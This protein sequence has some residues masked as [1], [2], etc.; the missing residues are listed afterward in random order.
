[1]NEPR[2]ISGSISIGAWELCFCASPGPDL[3]LTLLR[4][5]N[6]FIY[7]LPYYREGQLE[8]C[9]QSGLFTLVEY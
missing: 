1:M 4:N 3:T 9:T 7:L 5:Y 6:Q 2:S 8:A